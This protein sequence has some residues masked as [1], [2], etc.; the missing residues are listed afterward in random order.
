MERVNPS[1]PPLSPSN[2][3]SEETVSEW[4]QRHFYSFW[5]NFF[6]CGSRYPVLETREG[7]PQSTHLTQQAN[8]STTALFFHKLCSQFVGTKVL[9]SSL[10]STNF[11][12][13]TYQLTIAGRELE[14][15][16]LDK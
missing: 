5:C 3:S 4:S 8:V 1:T 13:A 7:T 14:V 15:K 9:S 16:L 6:W 12:V 10:N 11:C 2:F